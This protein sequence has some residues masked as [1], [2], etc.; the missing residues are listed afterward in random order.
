[1]GRGEGFV[2][3]FLYLSYTYIYRSEILDKHCHLIF[4]DKVEKMVKLGKRVNTKCRGQKSIIINP[5]GGF[6]V[7]TQMQDVI[8][9]FAGCL[10]DTPTPPSA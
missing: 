3:L 4:K 2:L 8:F 5:A 10:P 7:A 1:M 6:L 9:F